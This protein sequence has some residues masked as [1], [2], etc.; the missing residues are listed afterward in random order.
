[1]RKLL[2]IGCCFLF[3]MVH[4]Q[5]PARMAKSTVRIINSLRDTLKYF[6]GFTQAIVEISPL[7]NTPGNPAS[8]NKGKIYNN[9]SDTLLIP[10]RT[11]G[12]LIAI[13]EAIDKN[14]NWQPIEY[15]FNDRCGNSFNHFEL[16]PQYSLNFE[17]P[18][19]TGRFKTKM[20]LCL[21]LGYKL[22]AFSNEWE[23]Y[24]D[25]KQFEKPTEALDKDLKIFYDFLYR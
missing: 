18:R 7:N 15:F 20:R 13:Q 6:S 2:A 19:Y 24:I 11:I 17:L 22:F 16:A 25:E 4:A 1:M 21:K 23:A 9:T 5:E 8:I 12:T 14:G 10:I 3:S